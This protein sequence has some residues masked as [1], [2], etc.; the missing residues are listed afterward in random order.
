V[1]RMRLPIQE[2]IRDLTG[3]LLGRGTAV[4]KADEAI[5][6]ADAAVIAG[7]RDDAGVLQVLVPA[8]RQLVS[9]LGGSLVMVPEVVIQEAMAKGEV[10]DH[11]VEN[12]WE[13]ANILS[14]LLNREG[15]SHVMLADRTEGV[16]ALGDDGRALLAAPVR[17]R[18]FSIT[19]QGYGTGRLG[20]L[21]AT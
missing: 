4:D 19:V 8:D 21:A 13:V 10:A 3:E 7:Y 11:L 12:F 14:S 1:A 15:A 2:A 16:D 5:A 20:F 18:W 17:A 9:V 6:P